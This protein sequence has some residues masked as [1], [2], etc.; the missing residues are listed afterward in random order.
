MKQIPVESVRKSLPG[1]KRALSLDHGKFVKIEPK[2]ITMAR[3][4][5]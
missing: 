3:Q 4:R 5:Q 1:P 2:K